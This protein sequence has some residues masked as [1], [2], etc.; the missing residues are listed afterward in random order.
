MNLMEGL[1]K[2]INRCKEVLLPAYDSIGPAGLFASTMIRATIAKA[3]QAMGR[4]DTLE[5]L[6]C[7]KE[8]EEFSE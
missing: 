8:L 1:I 2:Q 4:G 6:A 7:Y 3:E 5:M